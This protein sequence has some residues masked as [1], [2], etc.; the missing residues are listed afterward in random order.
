MISILLA[1]L[2]AQ[3]EPKVAPTRAATL[4]KEH[5]IVGIHDRFSHMS[6]MRVRYVS[7]L[8]FPARVVEPAN[9]APGTAILNPR[10]DVTVVRV[11]PNFL[12]DVTW[13][14]KD[15]GRRIWSTTPTS[16]RS[17]HVADGVVYLNNKPEVQAYRY[18]AISRLMQVPV[19]VKHRNI[20]DLKTYR[21]SVMNDS[22]GLLPWTMYDER[23]IVLPDQEQVDGVW[24]HVVA[25]NVTQQISHKYWVDPKC[26]F[27][28][29]RTEML[30][31]P[32]VL[33]RANL[34]NWEKA[35]K[36]WFPRKIM[37]EQFDIVPQ[38]GSVKVKHTATLR[39]TIEEVAI[40]DVPANAAEIQ[41]VPG[42]TVC[43]VAANKFTVVPGEPDPKYLKAVKEAR[44]REQPR[45]NPSPTSRPQ[46]NQ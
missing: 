5:I 26:D 15:G 31:G 8:L 21:A 1:S 35:G 23:Y 19:S 20:T 11:D 4:E 39:Y 10:D 24:C 22:E 40:G 33:S 9:P 13:R 38:G 42:M 16:S 6:S 17:F 2:I 43:D 44:A 28:V 36:T 37:V 46:T 27:A 18:D 14:P 12:V 30:T 32:Y 25:S 45:T 41:L 3:A 34:H 7:D 29:R